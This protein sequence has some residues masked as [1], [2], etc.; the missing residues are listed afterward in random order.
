MRCVVPKFAN[1][2]AESINPAIL[3]AASSS[4]PEQR[5]KCCQEASDICS[6]TA[7]SNSGWGVP[8]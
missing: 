2:R 5:A 3:Y 6:D 1:V 7:G 8:I 4:K